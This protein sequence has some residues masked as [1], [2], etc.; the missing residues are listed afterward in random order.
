MQRLI[1]ARAADPKQWEDEWYF[2][3]RYS[4]QRIFASGLQIKRVNREGRPPLDR[5]D[6]A[7]WPEHFDIRNYTDCHSI[8]PIWSERN[9]PKFRPVLEQAA[10]EWLAWSDDYIARFRNA[11]GCKG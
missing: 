2:M 8:R 6:R 1:E 10:P 4:S 5:L 11:M 7:Y 9:Y 3:Q